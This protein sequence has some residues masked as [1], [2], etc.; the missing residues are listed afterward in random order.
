[1]SRA[2]PLRSSAGVLQGRRALVVG[3][4]GLGTPALL[5]LADSG[6]TLVIADDDV[7]ELSNLHRQIL[8]SESDVGR[9]KLDAVRDALEKEGVSPTRI[10]LV[11]SRFLPENAVELA[12][13]VDIVLEGSDNFATKFLAADAAHLAGRPV[14]HG[15]A[16][17]LEGTVWCV[18]ARG[19][20]CYRCLFEDVPGGAQQGCSEAGV[21]APVVGICGALMAELA[22]RALCGLDAYEGS[23]IAVNGRRNRLR[24]VPVA[25]RQSCP[26][27]GEAPSIFEIVE[28]R[29]TAP[30]CAA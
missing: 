8:F 29:Y 19:A 18:P 25:A 30:S 3:A 11:R 10:E 12:R 7:V 28:T 4:G 17:R 26:L 15:A 21:L 5:A 20:P 9:H 1:M 22:L 16:V 24:R 2:R 6:A 13:G 23:L 14:V 27:C